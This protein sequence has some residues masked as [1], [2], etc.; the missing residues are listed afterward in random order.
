[1][2]GALAEGG[3]LGLL[4]LLAWAALPVWFVFKLAKDWRGTLQQL[5]RDPLGFVAMAL[6]LAGMV[7]WFGWLVSDGILFSGGWSAII[8]IAGL[9]LFHALPKRRS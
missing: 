9:I 1:M 6:M 4:M 7:G 3:I 5:R 8:C 2:T